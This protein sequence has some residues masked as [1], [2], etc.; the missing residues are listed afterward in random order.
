MRP[1]LSVATALLATLLPAAC[2][3]HAPAPASDASAPAVQT[4][5]VLLVSIDAFRAD[6]LDRGV[7][8]HLWRFARE[9]VR[10]SMR[11]SYPSLTFP[12]HYSMV[13]GLRPD[14]HGIVHN[15]MRDPV[16]GSFRASNEQSA[17]DGR[18]WNGGVPLWV[19]AARAGLPTA[20][21]FWPGTQAE[22]HGVRPTQWRAYD[23]SVSGDA[24]VDQVLAWLSQ[25][26]ARRPRFTTLYFEA[27]DETGHD[28]GPESREMD[29]TLAAVDAS[30]GRLRDGLARR[31]LL[32]KVNLVI[33][34]DHGVA[35][36]APGH[37]VAIEDMVDGNDV[38]VHSTG[39]SVG[40]APLP[41]HQAAAEKQ[42]LG[43][44]G[45]YACWRKSELPAR[46]HYGTHPRVPPIICQMDEGWDAIPRAEIAKRPRHA[47]GSHGYDPELPSM[48]ALF[49]GHGPAFRAGAQLPVFDNVD[50]YPLLAR[51]VGVEAEPGDGDFAPLLPALRTP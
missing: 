37:V 31:G 46:W 4:P 51:L 21:M 15:N 2:A 44:H 43:R 29:A 40:F 50:V 39:Q 11:P 27:V 36:V 48:R 22:I 38:A 13:T 26:A 16:L 34:S 25:P 6:F 24:R 47:R 49:V 45:H 12:N 30:I 5:P 1:I 20:A 8:P 7:T 10:G 42:L 35:E 3:T 19:S 41:G 23:E 28:F 17:S 18:W 32:D 33:V 9:G 14:R